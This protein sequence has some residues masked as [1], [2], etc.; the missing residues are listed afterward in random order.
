MWKKKSYFW[1]IL[2]QINNSGR[3]KNEVVHSQE[4]FVEES[5]MH[6]AGVRAPSPGY[7]LNL[8]LFCLQYGQTS[9]EIYKIWGT[10]I[11]S[12]ILGDAFYNQERSRLS[13]CVFRTSPTCICQ[14]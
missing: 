4:A 12:M 11:C 8:L 14:F 2:N 13:I 3:L 7:H 9:L 10:I 5:G 6:Y 1:R